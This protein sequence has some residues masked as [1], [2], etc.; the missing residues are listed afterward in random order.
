MRLS[1]AIILTLGAMTVAEAQVVLNLEQCLDMARSNNLEI[2]KG[3]MN[4]SMA[5]IAVKESRFSRMPNLNGQV[6]ATY[7]SGKAIDPT[8]N[9]FITENFLGND[10]A[11][12]GGVTIYAGGR[13]N[14]QIKSDQ[15]GLEIAQAQNAQLSNDIGLMVVNAY[16]GVL[17]GQ[18]N[19]KNARA[20]LAI[21]LEQR[22]DVAKMIEAGVRAKN[23]ILDLEVQV[24]N[25]EQNLVLAENDLNL[26]II[27]LKQIIRYDGDEAISVERP[28]LQILDEN[29]VDRYSVDMMYQHAVRNLPGMWASE[30]AVAQSE[31]GL[32]LSQSA[33]FPTI[34]ANFSL[35]TRY[36]DAAQSFTLEDQ[37][38][39]LSLRINN[40]NADVEVLNEV[41]TNFQDIS[42]SDQWDQNLGYGGGLTMTVPIFNRMSVQSNVQRARLNLEQSA[43]FLDEA[44]DQLRR[45]LENALVVAKNAEKAWQASVKSLEA[46]R[47]AYD[48]TRKRFNVGNASNLELSTA[49]LLFEN[50]QRLETT[51]KYTYIFRIKVLDFYLGRDLKL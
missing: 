32:K 16:L 11:L 44:K 21:S 29:I 12:G 26:Q 22:E 48:N 17:A 23:D 51:N 30:L 19:V 47:A 1:T 36:S 37:W 3:E 38:I 28:Q 46:T 25:D 14:N 35:N 7:Y 5:E 4:A 9:A 39:P 20:Q 43:L 6:N 34:S 15:L 10:I 8:T 41:P 31:V 24:I 40:M 27:D 50:A 18:E 33:Y 45:D 2:K 49:K 42:I 13:I